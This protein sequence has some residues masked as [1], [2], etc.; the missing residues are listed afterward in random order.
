[1]R[2]AYC[3]ATAVAVVGLWAAAA[4]GGDSPIQ[5]ACHTHGLMNCTTCQPGP[6]A[7]P[8]APTHPLFGCCGKTFCDHARETLYHT[9][10][11]VR[12]AALGVGHAARVT[13]QGIGAL[14]GAGMNLLVY[15]VQRLS[16]CVHNVWNAAAC[17]L[18]AG[19]GHWPTLP[20]M[21]P[22]CAAC[23]AQPAA[24][25]APAPAPTPSQ[26]EVEQPT[27]PAPQPAPKGGD[28][29]GLL[30]LRPAPR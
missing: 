21:V 11:A 8:A 1:M 3:L 18:C 10:A 25:A 15:K 17:P 13:V 26:P 12:S 27:V 14:A 2:K 24:P 6:V 22:G 16:A 30:Q 4:Q 5:L 7:L 23:G 29:T 28:Q 9:G 19:P 20:T